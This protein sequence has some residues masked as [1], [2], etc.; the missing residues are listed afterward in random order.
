M[1]AVLV[2]HERILR[3][4]S[5]NVEVGS[6]NNFD[7]DLDHHLDPGIFYGWLQLKLAVSY[8]KN[9][10]FL[11]SKNWI[12]SSSNFI[13]NSPQTV[14]TTGIMFLHS[15]KTVNEQRSCRRRPPAARLVCDAFKTQEN[16]EFWVLTASGVRVTAGLT[17]GWGWPS[18]SSSSCFSLERHNK[19]IHNVSVSKG[20]STNL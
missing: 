5:G 3:K 13:L 8:M 11:C 20:N 10:I 14:Q 2:C 1:L 7:C 16:S 18:P 19:Y 15:V 12:L 9:T 4:I 17:L 6:K